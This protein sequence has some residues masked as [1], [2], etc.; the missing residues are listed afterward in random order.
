MLM[1]CA[2][3]RFVE[4]QESRK[5]YEGPGPSL[6]GSGEEN[7]MKTLIAMWGDEKY[8]QNWRGE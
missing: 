7:E 4:Q 6:G 1:C 3:Y 8:R 5:G 2:G